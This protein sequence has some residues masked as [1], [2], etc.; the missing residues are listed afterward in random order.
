MGGLYALITAVFGMFVKYFAE[1][2]TDAIFARRSF[3]NAVV[4][5]EKEY[6]K[7]EKNCWCRKISHLKDTDYGS[8]MIPTWS[9]IDL[10]LF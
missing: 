1:I 2:R 3:E 8:D 7:V 4:Y 9:F 6:D 10:R 5:T